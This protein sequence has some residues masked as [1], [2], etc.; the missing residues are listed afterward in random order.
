MNQ[1]S[2]SKERNQIA[3]AEVYKPK[4][5]GKQKKGQLINNASF[6]IAKP[7]EDTL[8]NRK[9][10]KI[11]PDNGEGVI[12][13]NPK[14]CKNRDTGVLYTDYVI[15]CGV[16]PPLGSNVKLL[17]EGMFPNGK[18]FDHKLSKKNPLKF[19]KGIGQVVRG[20]DLGLEGMRIGGSREIVIPPEL[21]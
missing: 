14:Q 16:E 1:E 8:S 18:I 13:P 12:V 5:V 7:P 19:R 17:Y 4:K 2:N 11:R 10:W 15:G 3:A 9:R 20:L 21:G 6:V